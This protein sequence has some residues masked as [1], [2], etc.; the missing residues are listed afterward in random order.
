MLLFEGP[1]LGHVERK[2]KAKRKKA[3]RL[4]VFDNM[5]ILHDVKVSLDSRSAD[6]FY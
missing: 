1:D 6:H 5:I 2:E 4:D 3:K